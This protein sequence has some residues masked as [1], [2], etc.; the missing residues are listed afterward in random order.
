MYWR[1]NKKGQLLIVLM[2]IAEYSTTCNSHI[3]LSLVITKVPLTRL[4]SSL[5][6]AADKCN[7]SLVTWLVLTV[8]ASQWLLTDNLRNIFL[9]SYPNLSSVNHS[10]Q[11][12]KVKYMTQ[13]S[14][15]CNKVCV[16]VS[17]FSLSLSVLHFSAFIPLWTS[18]TFFT[19]SFNRAF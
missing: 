6:P 14:D 13:H 9:K 7:F 18:D 1:Q 10:S 5:I 11:T 15:M 8:E 4:A 17:L 19:Q 12:T 2:G 16:C 3:P